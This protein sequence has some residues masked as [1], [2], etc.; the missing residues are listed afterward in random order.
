M[1]LTYEDVREFVRENG[2]VTAHTTSGRATPLRD[3]EPDAPAMVELWADIF[4]FG[5]KRYSRVEFH[6]LVITMRKSN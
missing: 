4:E 5:G 1:A 3:G 6:L 2:D